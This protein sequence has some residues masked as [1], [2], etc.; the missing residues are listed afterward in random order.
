MSGIDLR[1]VEVDDEPIP[2][3]DKAKELPT[4]T[5]GEIVVSGPMVTEG[6][7][8]DAAN[9]SLH[10]IVDGDRLF[11]RVG[12]VGYID[13]VG[14]VWFCGRKSHRVVLRDRVLFTVPIEKRFDV[15]PGVFR[16][17][18]V[19]IGPQSARDAALCIELEPGANKRKVKE[20]LQEI[21]AADDDTQCIKHYLFHEGFPVDIR[22]NAKIGREKLSKWA[23]TQL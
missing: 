16:T 22:H 18:L 4:G 6:Y 10:K 5:I 3:W 12:D 15:H 7:L 17:A 1:V 11:H 8:N 2:T 21:A 9:T 23:E 13:D 19:G 14:R 20:A